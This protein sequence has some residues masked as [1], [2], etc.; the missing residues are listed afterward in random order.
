[1][2]KT[3]NKELKTYKILI[4]GNLMVMEKKQIFKYGTL[5]EQKDIKA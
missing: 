5:Q 1:M 4:L 2:K 3:K